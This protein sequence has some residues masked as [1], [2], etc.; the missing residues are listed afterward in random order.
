[1]WTGFL[2]GVA[3]AQGIDPT[4]DT[5]PEEIVV[6][7]DDFARWDDT[8]WLVNSELILPLP[9]LLGAD[10]NFSFFSY[11]MQIRMV[12]LCEK[13]GKETRKRV[14]VMCEIEDIG[15]LA[16]SVRHWKREKDRERVARV[17]DEIDAKL[18]GA[19]IQLQVDFKGGVN[20]VDIEG[21]TADNQR[22]R[23]VNENLRQL[24][25]RVVAGFHMKI[26]DHAQRKGQWYEYNSNL[27]NL[28]SLS[29]ARG[30][31]TMAHTVSRHVSDG[32]EYQL[33]QTLGQ[34]STQ[35]SIPNW[36]A[37]AM[38]QQ[39]FAGEGGGNVSR[40]TLDGYDSQGPAAPTS[41]G[42]EVQGNSNFQGKES[43]VDATYKLDTT[44]VA[45]FERDT[46]IMTERVW[47]TYG[48]PTASSGGG[49]LNNMFR[50]IGQLRMLGKTDAPSVGPTGQ[51]SWP[52]QKPVEGLHVWTD[53][54]VAPK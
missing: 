29:A 43:G 28:P 45:V 54:D 21:L 33:V 17:L 47:A 35:V 30:S 26:P 39:G 53:L 1:M 15:L 40:A 49:T 5:S 22:Q 13:D 37:T 10:D 12:L 48:T 27:M 16:T 2:L 20:N 42:G 14:E 23:D 7:G 52:F 8:R 41:I 51:V 11:A 19:R 18:T 9:L 6:Y 44:G 34:G 25:L 36:D 24:L 50:N 46:G 31:T 38:Q 3:L 32:Y 4:I